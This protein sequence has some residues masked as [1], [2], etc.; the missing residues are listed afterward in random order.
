MVLS[1][2][3]VDEK[4]HEVTAVPELLALPDIHGCIVSVDALI[5]PEEDRHSDCATRWGFRAGA[6][7]QPPHL[8]ADVRNRFT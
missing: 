4:S 8:Y 7:R 1:Q 3:K 5:L 2:R 6:E